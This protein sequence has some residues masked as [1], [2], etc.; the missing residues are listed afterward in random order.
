MTATVVL[1]LVAG[2]TAPPETVT[3]QSFS[4]RGPYVSIDV[5]AV[6]SDGAAVAVAVGVP[7]GVPVGVAVGATW[8]QV[9]EPEPAA[10]SD[11]TAVTSMLT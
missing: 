6:W 9:A 2:G 1:T 7:V 10:P 3:A 4:R 5:T 8:L 11:Q